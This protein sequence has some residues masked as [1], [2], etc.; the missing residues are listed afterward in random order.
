MKTDREFLDG[1]YER[2]EKLKEQET[3]PV[4]KSAFKIYKNY[5]VS[6][7]AAVL[8]IIIIYPLTHLDKTVQKNSVSELERSLPF[9]IK[10]A[11]PINLSQLAKESDVIVKAK[12]K[13]I[14]KTVYEKDKDIMRTT[15]T[16][17]TQEVYKGSKDTKKIKI[18]VDNVCE[19]KNEANS[20]VQEEFKKDEITLLFLNKTDNEYILST[21]TDSKYT[22]LS[23]ENSDEIFQDSDLNV[24]SVKQL[25]QVLKEQ[26]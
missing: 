14:E 16:L 19:F 1:I 4:K 26:E 7:V 20:S 12:V 25:K 11:Q 22:Y 9:S 2:A 6:A 8:L 17:N 23:S 18:I 13:K 5:I 15:V 21:N 10:L 24:V 3:Q